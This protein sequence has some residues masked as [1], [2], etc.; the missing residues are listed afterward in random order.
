M[1]SKRELFGTDG[2]R[3]RAGS[4]P[5]TPELALRLGRAIAYTVR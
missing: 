2:I 3:G 5:M 4:E 1:T